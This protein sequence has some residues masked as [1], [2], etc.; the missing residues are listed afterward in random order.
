MRK[1][2]STCFLAAIVG[3]WGLAAHAQDAPA[4]PA[5]PAPPSAP[6]PAPEQ[7]S[8]EVT[9]SGCVAKTGET[10]KLTNAKASSGASA[11]DKVADEYTLEAGSGVN[12]APHV[13]HQVEVTGTEKTA[14]GGGAPSFS[15]SALKM[16][17]AKCE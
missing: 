4:P 9:L 15:V 14:A 16:T 12:F 5:P 7:K 11:P 1:A 6:A 2:I 3:A 17:A 10:F 13:S 8:S